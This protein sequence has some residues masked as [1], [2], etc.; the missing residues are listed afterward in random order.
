M[1]WHGVIAECVGGG[2]FGGRAGRARDGWESRA[3]V[4]YRCTGLALLYHSGI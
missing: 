4:G 3:G 2:D 1:V